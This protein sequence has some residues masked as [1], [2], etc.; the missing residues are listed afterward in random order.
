MS[1]LGEVAKD[2]KENVYVKLDIDSGNGGTYPYPF[3]PETDNMMYCMPQVGTIVSLYFPNFDEKNAMVVNCF[4]TNGEDCTEMSDSSKRAFNTEHGKCMALHSRTMSLSSTSGS[5]ILLDDDNGLMLNSAK[6][7]KF[8]AEGGLYLNAHRVNFKAQEGEILALTM[9]AAMEVTKSSVSMCSRFDIKGK[10]G[11]ILKGAVFVHYEPFDDAPMEKGFD[12]WE[13]VGNVLAGIAIAAVAAAVVVT[14]V[15]FI[16]VVLAA[17]TGTAIAASTITAATVIGG[18]TFTAG[19]AATLYTARQDIDNGYVRDTNT[20]LNSS[21]NTAMTVG[22]I[23]QTI[24]GIGSLAYGGYQLAK[25]MPTIMK[26]FGIMGRNASNWFLNGGS[27]FSGGNFALA[28]GGSYSG[29]RTLEEL[30]ALGFTLDEALALIATSGGNVALGQGLMFFS[31]RSG[32]IGTNGTQSS[33]VTKWKAKDSKARIDVENPAPGKRDGQ[34]HYQDANNKKWIY[35]I[36]DGKF[37]SADTNELAPRSIQ[38]LL[39][40]PKFYSGIQKALDLLGE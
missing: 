6:S 40:D 30:L 36:D 4:R 28:G 18:L 9:D 22:S 14:S 2:D 26:N 23:A 7:I 1:L 29:A 11:T 24:Y 25:N 13:L 19:T 16:P 34:I 21:W 5:S 12:V 15:L 39:D 3:R 27:G 35:N 20:Y 8:Y 10:N 17:A 31:Q 38:K 37:Y 33:S 32:P